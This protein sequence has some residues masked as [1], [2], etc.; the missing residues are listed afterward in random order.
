MRQSVCMAGRG[1]D[2]TGDVFVLVGPPGVG[3]YTIAGAMAVLLAERGRTARL[4]DN[5]YSCNPVFGLVAQDGVTQMPPA[6]ADR[7]DDVREA[8]ARTIE[9]LSPRE[10][11][12]IFTHVIDRPVDEGWMER[13][14]HVSEVR[15]S[16][17]AVVRVH[18]DLDE[19]LRRVVSESRRERMKSVSVEDARRSFGRDVEVLKKW[20]PLTID[21]TA[22]SPAESAALV[23]GQA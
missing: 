3:K 14:A 12:F 1:D 8:V 6:V 18:C 11:T 4:V 17:F 5:H 16:R 2:P 21:V 7:V 20:D 15:R 19:L 23:L 9:D 10:W 13:L 22:R